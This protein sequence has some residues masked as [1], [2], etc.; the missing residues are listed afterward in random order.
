MSSL[1]TSLKPTRFSP[2]GLVRQL[3][4][5]LTSAI[6]MLECTTY[7]ESGTTLSRRREMVYQ[8]LPGKG[9]KT[10]KEVN[11]GFAN[12]QSA[13]MGCESSPRSATSTPRSSPARQRK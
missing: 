13:R 4:P 5:Q 1:L 6:G 11:F 9:T 2:I 10:F 7:G 8:T 3:L 12:S